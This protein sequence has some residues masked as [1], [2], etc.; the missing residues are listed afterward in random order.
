MSGASA[1]L[2]QDALVIPDPA[3]RDKPFWGFVRVEEGRH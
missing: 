2:I 1:I 3:A